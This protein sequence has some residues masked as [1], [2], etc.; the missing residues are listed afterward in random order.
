MNYITQEHNFYCIKSKIHHNNGPNERSFILFRILINMGKRNKIL[1]AAEQLLAERGFDGLSMK[2]L[3]EK[4]GIAA[5]TIYRYFDNKEMLMVELHQHIRAEAAHTIFCGWTESQNSKEKYDRLWRNAFDAVLKNPQ[6]LA[7]I[8]MLYLIPNNTQ[9]KITIFEDNIFLPMID[10][11]QNGINEKCF[12]DWPVSA[13]V[14]LSFD[15]AIN[16][17]KKVLRQRLEMDEKVLE[18]VRDASW[19]AIQCEPSQQ[20]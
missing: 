2:V 15:S 16:L 9:H 7:V 20:I 13:L 5:G 3:A 6:R 1:V 18:Q 4:A 17:A 10:F 12:H 8:E 19:Q 11:Y 14:T